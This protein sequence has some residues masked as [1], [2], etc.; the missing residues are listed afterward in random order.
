MVIASTVASSAI[1]YVARIMLFGAKMSDADGK[2]LISIFASA[3][4]LILVTMSP[5]NLITGKRKEERD[6]F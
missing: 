1:T 4:A 6:G 3:F 2:L 5:I